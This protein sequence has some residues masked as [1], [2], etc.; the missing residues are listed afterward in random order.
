MENEETITIENHME[1]DMEV[2]FTWLTQTGLN[3]IPKPWSHSSKAPSK[4]TP[5]TEI[6]ALQFPG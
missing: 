6:S 3:K 5:S 4:N 1:N 2:R